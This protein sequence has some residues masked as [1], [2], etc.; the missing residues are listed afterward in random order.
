VTEPDALANDLRTVLGGLIRRLRAERRGLPLAQVA[1]LGR[2]DRG[3]PAGTSDLAAGERV[4]PQSMAS[5][6]AALTEAGLVDRRPDPGDRRRILISL[7]DRGRDVL[8]ADRRI[9]DAWLAEAIRRDLTAQERAVLAEA[10]GLL[11]RL[12]DSETEN[13][14]N[15]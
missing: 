12:V 7:T 11:A 1:V 4:R 13:H 14:P 5:T 10:A 3:G 6:V 15:G 9:R 2:L 8:L